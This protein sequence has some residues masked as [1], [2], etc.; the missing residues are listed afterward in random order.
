MTVLGI[1]MVLQCASL[2]VTGLG[3]CS[4][5]EAGAGMGEK[6]LGGGS[7]WW[8]CMIEMAEHRT[9]GALAVMDYGR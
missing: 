6:V 4:M 5:L 7:E 2:S 8:A 9:H 1:V 3:V